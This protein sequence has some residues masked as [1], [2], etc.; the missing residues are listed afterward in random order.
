MFRIFKEPKDERGG[1]HRAEIA[2]DQAMLVIE[3]GEFPV[4]AM[5]VRQ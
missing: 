5:G 2:Q 4:H 1:F 3:L